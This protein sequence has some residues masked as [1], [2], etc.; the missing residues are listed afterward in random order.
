MTTQSHPPAA[1][2]Q[3][4]SV[5][6]FSAWSFSFVLVI[7]YLGVFHLWLLLDPPGIRVTGSVFVALLL[8]LGA[9]AWHRSYF[10]NGWDAL[11]HGVVVADILVESWIPLHEGYGFYGC[12]AGFGLVLGAY[13]AYRLRCSR[14]R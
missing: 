4:Q 2:R 13:R 5:G 10:V 9:R 3:P 7:A 14:S 8:A 11:F 12:A 1:G 6:V